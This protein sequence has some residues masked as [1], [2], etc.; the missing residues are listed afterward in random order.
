MNTVFQ[1]LF[2]VDTFFT[3]GG[4]L[5]SFLLIKEL[6]KKNG[7]VNIAF[8]YIHRYVRLTPLYGICM[9]LASTLFLHL[10]NGP[11]WHYMQT[12]S[13]NCADS[14]WTNLLY[15]NNFVNQN[16]YA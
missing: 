2:S 14:W 11:F 16:K 1:A 4:F 6:E 12:R 9:L 10:S 7:K 5:M 3:L 13:D 15:I 8:M